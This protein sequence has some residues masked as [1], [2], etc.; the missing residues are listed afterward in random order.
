[1]SSDSQATELYSQSIMPVSYKRARSN[2]TTNA[3]V[4]RKVRGRRSKAKPSTSV[5]CY[6]RTAISSAAVA[7]SGFIP[8]NLFPSQGLGGTGFYDVEMSFS[9]TGVQLYIGAGAYA[10]VALPN[11]SDFTALYD[12]YRIDYVDV[13]MTFSN[14]VSS[15]SSAVPCLPI[16]YFA[17][18]YDDVGATN[19]AAIAQYDNLKKFQLGSGPGVMKTI[20]CY[21]RPNVQL[22]NSPVS[23]GYGQASRK[24]FLDTNSPAV[25][26]YGAKFV[27][28]PTALAGGSTPIGNICMS[29]KYHLTFK[30]TK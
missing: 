29:Y 1:M 9:L 30:N 21:P 17:P 23:T 16:I 10:N 19:L 14:N 20:R 5:H 13:T 22:Y 2:S 27:V 11:Y 3:L 4:I 18:D 7:G 26:Y 24:L 28:D 15:T 8:V 25:P 6:T 12:Q